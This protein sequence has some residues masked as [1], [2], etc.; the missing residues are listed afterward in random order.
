MRQGADRIR[1]D[2]GIRAGSALA[3]G[4]GAQQYLI[5]TIT[6]GA[7]PPSP[8]TAIGAAIGNATGIVTDAAGNVYVAGLNCVFRL[9][10]SGVLTLVAGTAKA[11]YGGDGGSAT[12]A[13]LNDPA[14][15]NS[16]ALDSAGNLYIAD[17]LNARIR[18]VSPWAL[19]RPTRR[20]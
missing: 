4:A 18:R 10:N 20:D 15:G 6:G 9:N 12:S 3:A 17:T 14:G 8:T 2:P 11:G 7:P 1:Q 16:I 5:S 19:A 13:Q